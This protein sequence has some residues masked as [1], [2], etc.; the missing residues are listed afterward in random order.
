MAR[1][2]AFATLKWRRRGAGEVAACGF[3]LLIPFALVL[4]VSEVAFSD[5]IV[6]IV[7][8]AEPMREQAAAMLGEVAK[9]M[10]TLSV[11]AGVAAA[12]FYRQPVAARARWTAT[13]IMA[14]SMVLAVVS[15]FSGL[16]F[17]H[18]MGVQMSTTE[19]N[20]LM[21]RSRLFLQGWALIGQ[22]SLLSLAGVV[23]HLYRDRRYK[24][25]DN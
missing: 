15:I 9:I 5:P 10:I 20:Y 21:I 19:I 24:A 7:V 13:P 2:W 4:L 22:V 6:P 1:K 25:K 12:F 8:F 16:R 23:H 11:G 14:A 18:D 3:A 17:L